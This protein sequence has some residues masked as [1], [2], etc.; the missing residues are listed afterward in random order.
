VLFK[1]SVAA[2]AMAV[3]GLQFKAW[4]SDVG[5][6]DNQ[7]LQAEI[8]AQQQRTAVLRYRNRLLTAEVLALQGGH[9]AVEAR[10]RVNL[11]MVKQGETFYLVSSEQR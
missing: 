9:D 11:G 5:Y 6:F 4:F 3:V 1:V 8:A 2:L 7:R 10:A